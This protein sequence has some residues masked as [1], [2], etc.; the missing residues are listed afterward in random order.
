MKLTALKTLGLAAATTVAMAASAFAASVYD[1]TYVASDVTNNGIHSVWFGDYGSPYSGSKSWKS[2][3][4]TKLVVD[5]MNGMTIAH[6]T[7]TIFQHGNAGNTIKVDAKFKL[8]TNSANFNGTK[9]GGG[10]G[11]SANWDRY[12]FLD[13]TLTGLTGAALG[14][15]F[16]L[17]NRIMGNGHPAPIAQLGYGANDKDGGL[18]FSTWFGWKDQDGN[19]GHGDINLK[20]TDRTDNIPP[21]PLPAGGLLLLTGLAGLGAAR[22]FKKH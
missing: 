21:V 12:T 15:I 9:C 18:G 5:D 19:T 2:S 17:T 20:L 13:A 7:G 8:E 16:T 6:Y 10:C 1:G 4:D 3:G 22:R 11:D 14:D